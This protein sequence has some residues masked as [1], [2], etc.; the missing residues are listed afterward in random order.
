MLQW[1]DV[2]L[3]VLPSHIVLPVQILGTLLP[4]QLPPDAPGKA[5]GAGPNAGALAAHWVDPDRVWSL[6]LTWCSLAVCWHLCSEP[7]DGGSLSPPPFFFLLL[8]LSYK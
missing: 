3:M 2:L 8:Y 6:A 7:L 1:V 4:S 5:M